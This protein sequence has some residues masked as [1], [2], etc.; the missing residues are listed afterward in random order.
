MK[1][2]MMQANPKF[3]VGSHPQQ[4]KISSKTTKDKQQLEQLPANPKLP[5]VM[6]Q[7]N[8]KFVVGRL[9]LTVDA[10]KLAGKSYVELHNYYINNYDKG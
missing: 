6:M 10:L 7:A 2:V 4:R 1:N 9:M 5:T 8:L 3:V